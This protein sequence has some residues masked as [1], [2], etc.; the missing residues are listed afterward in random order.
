MEDLTRKVFRV[1]LVRWVLST[2]GIRTHSRSDQRASWSVVVSAVETVYNYIVGLYISFKLDRG[3][4]L[5]V[6]GSIH[7]D[8]KFFFS[9]VDP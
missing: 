6:S 7:I 2:L 4:Q 9:F 1:V 5:D 3:T 8:Q